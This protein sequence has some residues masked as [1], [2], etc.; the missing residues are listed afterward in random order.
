MVTESRLKQLEHEGVE[1]EATVT[2]PLA[3]SGGFAHVFT[4]R[5][6]KSPSLVP[7]QEG[8]T[9]QVIGKMDRHILRITVAYTAN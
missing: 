8:K 2:P 1:S 4:E 7:R 9:E 6:P 3:S 5:L